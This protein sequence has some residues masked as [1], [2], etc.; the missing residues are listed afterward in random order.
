VIVLRAVTLDEKDLLEVQ[1]RIPESNLPPHAAGV[2]KE[3]IPGF[4]VA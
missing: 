1:K 4:A 3:K 2:G